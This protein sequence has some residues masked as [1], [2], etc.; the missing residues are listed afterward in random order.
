M[1]RA[2]T[3]AGVRSFEREE[4]RRGWPLDHRDLERLH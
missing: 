1:I 2:V 4:E 3:G